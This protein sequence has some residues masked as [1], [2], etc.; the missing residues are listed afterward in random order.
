MG[1]N[2]SEYMD[3]RN[4]HPP[5]G[6]EVETVVNPAAADDFEDHNYHEPSEMNARPLPNLPRPTTITNVHYGAPNG[7][8]EP[9]SPQYQDPDELASVSQ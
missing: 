6:L 2:N 7:I 5:R 8:P 3:H 1:T 9:S 4:Y